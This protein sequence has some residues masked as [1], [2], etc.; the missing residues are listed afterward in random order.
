M[1]RKNEIASQVISTKFHTNHI[2]NRGYHP[3]TKALPSSLLWR[4]DVPYDFSSDD[5][6]AEKPAASPTVRANRLAP[7]CVHDAPH[8]N[9]RR[10][11]ACSHTP[12]SHKRRRRTVATP[13]TTSRTPRRTATPTTTTSKTKNHHQAPPST[14]TS[15]GAHTSTSTRRSPCCRSWPPRRLAGRAPSAARHT[16]AAAT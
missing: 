1:A 3:P 14:S 13:T 12:P 6:D 2:D 15:T 16:A 4:H 11:Q 5:D 10:A 8:A 9:V 7:V